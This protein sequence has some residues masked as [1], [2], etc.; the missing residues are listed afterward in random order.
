MM[1]FDEFNTICSDTILF[2]LGSSIKF[3]HSKYVN[4][5]R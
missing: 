5:K 2:F 1:S 3:H 4:K